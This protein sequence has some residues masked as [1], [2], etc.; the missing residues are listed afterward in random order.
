MKK[1]LTR[2][3]FSSVFNLAF[4]FSSGV[5]APVFFKHYSHKQAGF[6]AG[7]LFMITALRALRLSLSRPYRQ[8][9]RWF[10]TFTFFSELV[11]WGWRLNEDRPISE[12]VILG[13]Q[14]S[15]LHPMMAMLYSVSC[16]VLLYAEIRWWRNLK[17]P[18]A[19]A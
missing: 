9:V 19:A 16:G 3:I 12:V 2:K 5:L 17:A 18:S 13:V 4:Y 14:G 15:R 8:W 1:D 11:F 7:G 10:F 6:L